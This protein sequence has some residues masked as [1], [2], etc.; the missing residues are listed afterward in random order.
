MSATN[1]AN[2]N[3][4]LKR[5]TGKQASFVDKYL[6][7][8]RFNASLAAKL[9]G[10]KATSKHSFEAI[11]SENLAKSRIRKTIDEYFRM[12]R[13]T[14]DEVL[15]ELSELARGSSKDKIRALALLSSHFGILDGAGA[16]RLVG[17]P[18][19]FNVVY[20]QDGHEI[21]QT[22]KV[23]RVPPKVSKEEWL[24]LLPTGLPDDVMESM[25]K[26]YDDQDGRLSN[27]VYNQR[28]ADA[29]TQS[30]KQ[31]NEKDALF[32]EVTKERNALYRDKVDEICERYKDSPEV[33]QA[34]QS[35]IAIVGFVFSAWTPLHVT[36]QKDLDCF[37]RHQATERGP[38]V[39]IIPPDRRLQPAAV[40]RLMRVTY[41]ETHEE[42][43]DQRLERESRTAPAEIPATT[44]GEGRIR[45]YGY[46]QPID[47]D[48]VERIKERDRDRVRIPMIY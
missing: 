1:N 26:V 17:G 13:M 20:D 45:P 24:E 8:A 44:A 23:V 9:A 14:A 21:A 16:G 18:V 39:E 2:G 10:Y 6:G 36:T 32:T 30:M 29:L 35:T 37:E 4:N 27:A 19:Q 43:Q 25:G 33:V 46:C 22:H 31:L 48:E 41:E 15:N 47:G 5:L 38:E 11:G 28:V 7:E 3:G 40:E 42:H 34:L 12:S